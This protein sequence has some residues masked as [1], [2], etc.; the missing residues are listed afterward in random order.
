MQNTIKT[1]SQAKVLEGVRRGNLEDL[2]ILVKAL[3]ASNYSL[4]ALD[5][6][7]ELLSDF[8][9]QSPGGSTSRAYFEPRLEAL[10]CL[11]TALEVCSELDDGN[12]LK[13]K[14]VQKVYASI[15][16]IVTAIGLGVTAAPLLWEG[17][18]LGEY[19]YVVAC[20]ILCCVQLDDSIGMT[21]LSSS[22]LVTHIFKIWSFPRT[23]DSDQ[24]FNSWSFGEGFCA[25]QHIMDTVIRGS[26]SFRILC[27]ILRAPNG[28]LDRFSSAFCSRVKL[29]EGPTDTRG[30][31][32][33]DAQRAYAVLWGN[34]DI[35]KTNDRIYASLRERGYLRSFAAATEAMSHSTLSKDDTL[36]HVARLVEHATETTM[37]NPVC[38]MESIFE[39]KLLP[40]LLDALI[41]CGPT[42]KATTG[43]DIL[44]RLAAYSYHPRVLRLF[45]SALPTLPPDRVRRAR[46]SN[47]L[48]QTWSNF[49]DGMEGMFPSLAAQTSR[50]RSAICD[51][52]IKHAAASWAGKTCSGCHLVVYCSS[53]CQTQDW[54]KRHR[55][56]CPVMKETYERRKSEGFRYG[57]ASRLFHLGVAKHVFTQN[58][59]EINNHLLLTSTGRPDRDSVV[60]IDARSCADAAIRL[61]LKPLPTYLEDVPAGDCTAFD[62]RLNA[63]IT[64]FRSAPNLRS[65]L[66]EMQIAWDIRRGINLVAEIRKENRKWK[67]GYS[68]V[69]FGNPP[70]MRLAIGQ[71]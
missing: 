62:S 64:R 54:D 25:F 9:P 13:D 69:W 66:V 42:L 35:L 56:E 37:G 32:R 47:V 36:S 68:V 45:G 51:N 8:E 65:R 28:D 12:H 24:V 19:L 34:I 60:V 33:I 21:L 39:C 2:Q 30:M 40:I 10:V 55:G 20:L 4:A 5:A 52:D 14:T 17:K 46:R 26:I 43:K 3:N 53:A 70:E 7:L 16:T 23:Y 63:L 6:L 71:G 29:L 31:S 59:D 67:L 58:T 48:G 38:A 18:E 1:V 44:H 27:N 11:R 49:V 50:K 61:S 41:E 22:S 15:D 57:H